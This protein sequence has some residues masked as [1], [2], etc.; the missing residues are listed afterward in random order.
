[1]PYW[2]SDAMIKLC[3]GPQWFSL[4]SLRFSLS[5]FSWF[6]LSR[7]WFSLSRSCGIAY[8]WFMALLVC[9]T[10]VMLI[11]LGLAMLAITLAVLIG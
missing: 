2:M 9:G 5:A 1:M 6:S 8:D 3:R 10:A 11:V 7:L 4:S